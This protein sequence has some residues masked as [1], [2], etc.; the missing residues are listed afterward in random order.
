[1]AWP[2]PGAGVDDELCAFETMAM[3]KWLCSGTDEG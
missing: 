3:R 1:L 2:G